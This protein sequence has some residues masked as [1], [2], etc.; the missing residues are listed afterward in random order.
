MR[1]ALFL[2]LFLLIAPAADAASWLGLRDHDHSASG[3]GG[4]TVK[5]D[6]IGDFVD[7]PYY[8]ANGASYQRSLTCTFGSNCSYDSYWAGP[9]AGDFFFRT[10]V[11][12]GPSGSGYILF[13]HFVDGSSY[14]WS[15]DNSSGTT[16]EMLRL[17]SDTDQDGAYFC[18][19]YKDSGT[20][21]TSTTSDTNDPDLDCA[22]NAVSLVSAESYAFEAYLIFDENG[23]GF[24][25]GIYNC[26]GSVG[27][28][29]WQVW[30][31]TDGQIT[32]GHTSGCS[33]G[34][35]QAQVAPGSV[36]NNEATIVRLWGSSHG[37][38]TSSGPKVIWA[39]NTSSANATNLRAGSYMRVWRIE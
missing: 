1:A 38:S 14:R 31:N 7:H 18:N 27:R 10:Y 20:A 32:Q 21:R 17:D 15:A 6:A 13:R 24:D 2:L 33:S 35:A 8:F 16:I 29:S 30:N 39:Q 28:Y 19:L 22:N 26:T 11:R 23:G 37:F 12:D 9:G 34:T 5:P 3:Q 4:D 36:T 25:A